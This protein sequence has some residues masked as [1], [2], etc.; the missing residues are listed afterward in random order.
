MIKLS[1]EEPEMIEREKSG[2]LEKI[3]LQEAGKFGINQLDI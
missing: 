1:A 3:M 2:M